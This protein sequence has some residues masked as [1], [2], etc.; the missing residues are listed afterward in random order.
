MLQNI[1]PTVHSLNQIQEAQLFNQASV[2]SLS[3]KK[4]QSR[5][6]EMTL[7]IRKQ[8]RVGAASSLNPRTKRHKTK[9]LRK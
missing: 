4:I 1:T 9:K 2:A 8:R 3:S 5:S 6:K 7:P